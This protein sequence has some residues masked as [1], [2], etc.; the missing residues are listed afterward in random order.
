[1]VITVDTTLVS[2]GG[3]VVTVDSTHNPSCNGSTDGLINISVTGGTAPYTYDWS[4]LTGTNDPQ[5]RP[6]IGAGTYTVTVTDANLCTGTETVTLTAPVALSVI[7]SG[8]HPGCANNN[9]QLL[10]SVSGGAQPY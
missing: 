10:A 4:D 7:L 9:G 3:P 2:D 1:C 8:T 6:N 5:N